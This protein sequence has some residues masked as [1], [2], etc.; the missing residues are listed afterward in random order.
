MQCPSILIR[1]SFVALVLAALFS[2]PVATARADEKSNVI[3]WSKGSAQDT[4]ANC[5][6]FI[7]NHINDKQQ[8]ILY[9]RGTKSNTCSFSA[10]GLK[11]HYPSNHGPTDEGTTTIYYF[12]RFG[13]DVLVEWTR[14]Y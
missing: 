6:Q 2:T 1:L 8:Y 13:S 9:V 7:M 4:P 10:D 3:D 14:G 12:A 5:G 11:F